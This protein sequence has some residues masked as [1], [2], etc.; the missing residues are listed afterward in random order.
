LPECMRG[1]TTFISRGDYVSG[2]VRHTYFHA[3]I[4][5]SA[6]KASLALGLAVVVNIIQSTFSETNN[7]AKASLAKW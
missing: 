1:P 7:K 3:T 4:I 2:I 5:Y 6:A